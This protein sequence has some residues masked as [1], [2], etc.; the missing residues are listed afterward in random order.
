MLV[1]RGFSRPAPRATAL[2]IGN[3]DGVHLGH[4]ALL[5]RLRVVAGD[6]GLLPAVLTFEPHPRD[7]FSPRE[8]PVRLSTLRE[9][10]EM[11]AEESVALSCVSRFTARF[12]ALSAQEFIERILVGALKAGYLIVGDDFRFGAGRAG[13]FGELCAAG[14]RHGFRVERM[15]S[16]TQDGER[17]SSSMVRA[18]LAAGEMERAARLLG[19]PYALDGRV[20]HGDKLARGLGFAT[21][22]IRVKHDPPPLSGVFAVEVRGLGDGPHRG[23]ANLGV[24][25][26]ARQAAR[27]LLEVHLFDFCADI[28]GAHLNVRFRHKLRNEKRFSSFADLQA[29]IARDIESARQYFKH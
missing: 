9:K 20:V 7:F 16:V 13:D 17:V 6:E 23:V 25:P 24:R 21:A 19:R 14:K 27:P 28:Y 3:F 10:L 1:F 12:A 5:E 22:N 8:A 11:L 15:R 18:A 29:Q 26:S 4:R 2:T